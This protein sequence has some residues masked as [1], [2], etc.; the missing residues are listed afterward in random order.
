M[1]AFLHFN[2]HVHRKNKTDN[3]TR[4]ALVCRKTKSA[5]SVKCDEIRLQ[6]VTGKLVYRPWAPLSCGAVAWLEVDDGIVVL[7]NPEADVQCSTNGVDASVDAQPVHVG[8]PEGDAPPRSRAFHRRKAKR[9][10]DAAEGPAGAGPGV[11]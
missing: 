10:G 11:Q 5:K 6:N 8:A 3:G 1:P 4:K 2:S 9:Q 7:V